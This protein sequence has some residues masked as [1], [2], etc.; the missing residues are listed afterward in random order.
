MTGLVERTPVGQPFREVTTNLPA[1]FDGAKLMRDL[2]RV[3]LR[4]TL[5]TVGENR[6]AAIADADAVDGIRITARELA[7]ALSAVVESEARMPA[8][9]ALIEMKEISVRCLLIQLRRLAD[10][11]PTRIKRLRELASGGPLLPDGSGSTAL[12]ELFG[13]HL[14]ET[15][16]KHFERK[17]TVRAK[18]NGEPSEGAGFLIAANDELGLTGISVEAV[19]QAY[20]RGRRDRMR[21]DSGT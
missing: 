5:A 3:G 9:A 8:R 10:G 14:P 7:A 11:L 6:G 18:R 12:R 19:V 17:C 15:Y 4:H 13:W 16:E 20:K 2:R 21:R 1:A